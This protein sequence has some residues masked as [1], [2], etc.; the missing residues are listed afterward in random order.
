MSDLTTALRAQ[1]HG[2]ILVAARGGPARDDLAAIYEALSH[3]TGSLWIAGPLADKP[4]PTGSAK[5]W[6][7]EC[8]P[9]AR[10]AGVRHFLRCDAHAVHAVGLVDGALLDLLVHAALSGSVSVVEIDAGDVEEA[11]AWAAAA[12]S[13]RE[14]LACALHSVV[15]DGVRSAVDDGARAAIA[16]RAADL[17]PP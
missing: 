9:D 7:L 8:P 3:T 15:V 17:T 12:T 14:S 10:E 13:D 11:L 2:V 6:L 16:A 5:V 4:A 1:N